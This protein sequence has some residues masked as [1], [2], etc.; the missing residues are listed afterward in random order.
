MKLRFSN[1]N[2]LENSKSQYADYSDINNNYNDTF[3]NELTQMA[4][5]SEIK[6]NTI[7]K[8]KSI[9]NF[10]GILEAYENTGS[11]L[12]SSVTFWIIVL[13][14]ILL[15]ILLYSYNYNYEVSYQN[16]LTPDVVR[17]TILGFNP[18]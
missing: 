13:L 16:G 4:C 15:I 11:Y 14:I 8:D 7:V 5:S 18:M 10:T 9:G 17:A 2:D 1:N 3:F 6:K 12:T